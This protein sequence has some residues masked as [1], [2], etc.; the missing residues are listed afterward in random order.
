MNGVLAAND[1]LWGLQSGAHWFVQSIETTNL[2]D[3]SIRIYQNPITANADT[4][5]GYSTFI[6]EFPNA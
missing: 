6:T 1:E 3:A 2:K 4:D 5:Y